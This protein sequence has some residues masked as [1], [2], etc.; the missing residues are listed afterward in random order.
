[1]LPLTRASC[2]M[3]LIS[4][5]RRVERRRH[6]F[7]HQRGLVTFDEV[8]RPPISAEQLLQFLA[9]DAGEQRRVGNL[10]A[11]EM[12]NRQHRA[13][14]GRIEEF[15]GMPRGGQRSGFRFAIADHTGDD[16]IGIVEHRPERMAERITQ[17]AAFVDRARALRRGMAGDSSRK[18]KLKKE[19]SQSGFILADIRID[20]AVSALEIGVAHDCRAAVSRDR[21]HKSCRGRIS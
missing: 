18:R 17:L 2:W 1:M 5:D 20:F 7:V 4:S 6:G 9:S 3:L 8:R 11:V 16:E 12:Q 14:R 21:K 13:V 19:L 15:I 10:V